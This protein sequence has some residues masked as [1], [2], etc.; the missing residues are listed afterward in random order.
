MLAAIYGLDRAREHAPRRR[1]RR[2]ARGRRPVRPAGPQPVA[3][4]ADALRARRV[5]AARARDPV[6]RRADH[7]PR[8]PGQA[9]LPRAAR[10]ASTRSGAP[11]SSS[12]RT[13]SPTSSTSPSGPSS[14]TTARSSTTTRSPP[15]AARCS[16]TK[17]VEVGLERADRAARPRRRHGPRAHRHVVKLVVD[18]APHV[19]PRRCSTSCS[20]GRRSPTSP[21]STRR[22]SRSS[23]RSTSEPAHVSAPM[24]RR[25]GVPAD[26]AGRRL[27][28][29]AR[30]AGRVASGSTWSSSA[31]LSA[32]VARG[33]GRQRRRPRRL[34]GRRP[35]L[36]HRH[37]RGGHR[38]LNTRLIED[39]GNDIGTGAVAVEL[40]RPASVLGV[41]VATE[42]GAAC[43]GSRCC[44][45]AGAC[46]ATIVAG[47]PPST[48][49]AA[50]RRCRARA[51]HHREP[52]RP[53]RLRRR[54][55]LDPRRR[56][57]VVPLPEAGVHPRRDAHPARG[58]AR[59][60]AAR[61]DAP[62]VP[63]D[64]LRPGP[65]RVR[66]VEPGCC[67]CRSAGWSCC[68]RRRGRL[69]AGERRLQV[70]GG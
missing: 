37:V 48:A 2:A 8:P 30:R 51:R 46:C 49:G 52:R 54:R 33:G 44:C 5:P 60:A 11:R 1:A 32:P 29:D 61:R 6:P 63:G 56:V 27:L 24:L 26:V 70:V 28:A 31:V 53:A 59:R 18:T 16:P 62:A 58:A 40:L 57:G 12:R 55:L 9:A 14:S 19:D 65:A 34:H 23:P 69:R 4:P 21:S 42:V 3:R 41:R 47:P 68:R 39:I 36:V 7:R 22:S 64:G 15:C 10:R 50:P 25:L 35:H 17:L 66:H 45:V 20:T 67:S 43:R 13:T 38:A